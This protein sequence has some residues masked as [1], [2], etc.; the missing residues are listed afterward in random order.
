MCFGDSME[1]IG[2]L[3]S[4]PNLTKFSCLVTQAA[5]HQAAS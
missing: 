1:V 4:K 3:I 5:C 2:L